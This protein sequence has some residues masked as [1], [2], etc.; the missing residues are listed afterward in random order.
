MDR[1]LGNKDF[2]PVILG[3]GLGAYNVARCLHEAYGARSL[4]LGRAALPETADSRIIDVEVVTSFDTAEGILATLDAV[5]KKLPTRKLLL[6]PTIEFYTNVVADHADKLNS[7][8]IVPG[9]SKDLNDLLLDKA[10][11]YDTCRRAGVAYPETYVVDQAIPDDAQLEECGITYPLI[12]KPSNTDLY[13]RVDFE[14][15][16]KVYLIG[17]AGELHR[18]ITDIRR[19]GYGDALIL[20][21]YISGD[22]TVMKVANCYSDSRGRVSGVAPAQVIL[23]DRHPQRVGNNDALMPGPDEEIAT[24]LRS[25]LDTLGYRGFVNADFLYDPQQ[26]RYLILEMNLRLGASAHYTMSAGINLVKL[27]VDDLVYNRYVEACRMPS[28]ESLW[29]NV[30][31]PLVLATA[32]KA[33]RSRAARAATRG[34]RHTLFYRYDLSVRRLKRI[35]PLEARMV[36]DHLR[37]AESVLNR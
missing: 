7:R 9:I 4:A 1:R 13:P 37:Y 34:L 31:L 5:A 26:G 25:F 23:T 15:K 32:P 35:L 36:R 10:D 2:V 22:E 24:S 29:I 30:P 20:Q 21:R 3:T 12:L 14:G 33:L 16:K 18:T 19:G 11:F 27:M 17:D 6:I 28:E 8:Y